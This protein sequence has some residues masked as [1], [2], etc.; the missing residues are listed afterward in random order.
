MKKIFHIFVLASV[1]IFVSC[2]KIE[3]ENYLVFSGAAG[4]WYEGTGV[5]DHSQRA[6]IEKYTGVRCVNCPSADVAI[7]AATAN[8]TLLLTTSAVAT[9]LWAWWNTT[10]PVPGSFP[11][12]T[13]TPTMTAS[14]T[15]TTSLSAIPRMQRACKS[16][17]ANSAKASSASAAYADRYPPATASLSA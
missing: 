6:I 15:T 12:A 13:N 10:S 8:T 14:A 17:T 4:E 16:V 11:S 3:Q 1:F 2:D 7:A 5:S 9:G